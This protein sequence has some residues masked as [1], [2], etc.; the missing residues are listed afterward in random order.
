MFAATLSTDL[1][2]SQY[3]AR[4]NYL[5]EKYGDVCDPIPWEEFYD[6]KIEFQGTPIYFAGDKGRVVICMHGAGHSAMQFAILAQ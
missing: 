4:N 6:Q 2:S 3:E 5:L 1:K